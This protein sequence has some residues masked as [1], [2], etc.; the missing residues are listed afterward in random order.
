MNASNVPNILNQIV[1]NG[2]HKY[3]SSSKRKT[4]A[5][6]DTSDKKGA[7]FVVENKSDLS[8]IHI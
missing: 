2:L 4:V 5:F 8:L 1:H 3:D 7:V 6:A